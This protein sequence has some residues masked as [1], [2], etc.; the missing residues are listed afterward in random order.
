MASFDR[1]LYRLLLRFYPAAFRR[2]HAGELEATYAYCM[3]VERGRRGPVAAR[4]VGFADAVRG[5]IALRR[6]THTP[7]A[8]LM[9]T[10][11]QD[12]R[13][14]VRSFSRQPLFTAGLVAVLALGI[15]ANGAIFSLV[16]AVLLEPPP[17]CRRPTQFGAQTI[18]VIVPQPRWPGLPA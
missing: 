16:K 2:D 15:G 8:T 6:R 12:L 3:E 7:R 17:P 10:L 13:F 1:A 11:V 4:L 18:D 5:A 14:A 9:S